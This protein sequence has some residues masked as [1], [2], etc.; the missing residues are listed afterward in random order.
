MRKAS[1]TAAALGVF[2]AVVAPGI[3]RPEHRRA[4]AQSNGAH[5]DD[6]CF[7]T[8]S[9]REREREI[10]HWRRNCDFLP[11]NRGRAEAPAGNPSS[12]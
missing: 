11:E 9:N 4:T 8:N 6:S 5:H 7:V 10:R 1:S 12:L 3:A 2:L